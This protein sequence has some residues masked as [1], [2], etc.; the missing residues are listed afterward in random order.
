MGMRRH[1]HCLWLHLHARK[2]RR[3]FDGGGLEARPPPG[4]LSLPMLEDEMYAGTKS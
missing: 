3:T 4:P 1:W 2:M